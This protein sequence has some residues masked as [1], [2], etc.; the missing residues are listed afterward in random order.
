MRLKKKIKKA[1]KATIQVHKDSLEQI[2]NHK[3]TKQVKYE[4]F[5]SAYDYVDSLFP[6]A[7]VK[8]ATVYMCSRK[9]LDKIGYKGIGGFYSRIE[10]IVVIP[11]S[12]PSLND[13]GTF[14]YTNRWKAIVANITQE[15]ILVHELLHYV[16][17]KICDTEK[18]MQMEEEFA[19]GN[20]VDFCRMRGRTDENI[21]T[22][23]FLPY[24][25]TIIMPKKVDNFELSKSD[26]DDRRI[27]DSV[28]KESIDL[29]KSIIRIWDKKNISSKDKQTVEVQD[30]IHKK[31]ILDME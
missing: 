11:D 1:N 9:F 12:M 15:E 29:G 31:I 26:E 22:E 5:S 18:K 8:E 6:E 7:K 28:L 20:M 4:D 23:I 14:S 21:I 16:S 25:F 27:F 19:Y 2:K 3:K 30:F 17:G 13:S 10:K 24:L